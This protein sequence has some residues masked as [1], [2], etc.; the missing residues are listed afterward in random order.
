MANSSWFCSERANSVQWKRREEKKVRFIEDD[1][2]REREGKK[3]NEI[4]ERKTKT[5]TLKLK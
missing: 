4:E 1:R 5:K 3:N 2:E